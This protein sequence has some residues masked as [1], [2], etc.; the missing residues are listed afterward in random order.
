[1]I[2][3]FNSTV[4]A[5]ALVCGMLF[6]ACS[7]NKQEGQDQKEADKM[8]EMKADKPAEASS[9][10]VKVFENV[11]PLVKT[12]INGF[13]TEYFARMPSLVSNN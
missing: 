8:T 6:S 13:L 4:C 7:G 5:V 3:K 12:Q 10:E 2:H 11:D 1:M 9:S